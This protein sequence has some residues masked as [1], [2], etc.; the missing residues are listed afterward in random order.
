MSILDLATQVVAAQLANVQHFMFGEIELVNTHKYIGNSFFGRHILWK[1]SDNQATGPGYP[2]FYE[3]G[4]LSN[5][6]QAAK[7]VAR[8]Y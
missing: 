3:Q 8:S 7:S 2:G 5:L 6:P 1:D 4:V